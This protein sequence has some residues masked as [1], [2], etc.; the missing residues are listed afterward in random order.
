MHEGSSNSKLQISSFKAGL[1]RW[2]VRWKIS[3]WRGGG[4]TVA[5]ISIRGSTMRKRR[6]STIAQMNDNWIM[7]TFFFR[8]K[9]DLSSSGLTSNSVQLM[10]SCRCNK[11][12]ILWESK[13]TK[14]ERGKGGAGGQGGNRQLIISMGLVGREARHHAQRAIMQGGPPPKKGLILFIGSACHSLCGYSICI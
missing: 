6:E 4:G 8:S 14:G 13:G 10:S 3:G 9:H 5:G 12:Y 7:T 2:H 11:H 1:Y